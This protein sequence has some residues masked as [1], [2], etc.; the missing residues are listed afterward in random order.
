[1][2]GDK[3][4]KE[5]VC[6]GGGPPPPQLFR[7]GCAQ[8]HSAEC[9]GAEEGGEYEVTAVD[10]VNK[11]LLGRLASVPIPDK[12]TNAANESDSGEEWEDEEDVNN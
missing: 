3:I 9:S 10:E 2:E 7:C 11:A 5:G 8:H 1:M 12:F 4:S 6:S